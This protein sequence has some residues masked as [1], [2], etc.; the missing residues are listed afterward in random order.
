M[1]NM[2]T[3]DVPVWL[4]VQAEDAEQARH[5][6]LRMLND[7]ATIEQFTEHVG[8]GNPTEIQEEA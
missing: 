8:V 4:T 7:S 6:V 2:K 5:Q 3:F 1:K